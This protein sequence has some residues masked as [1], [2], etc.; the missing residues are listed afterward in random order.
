MSVFEIIKLGRR[1]LAKWPER[2]ELAQYFAEY[3]SIRISRLVCRYMPVLAV[4]VFIMQLYLGSLA[5]LPQALVYAFFM[6]SMPVQALVILGVKADKF[7]PPALAS[8]YKEG[9]AKINENGGDIKLSLQKPRYFDL[10]C[11]LS[12][13][14]KKSIQ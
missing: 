9:V 7:L 8:W 6:L 3:H 10:A 13:T 14:Y 12:I 2:A 4:V 1:Y 5:V 11:L